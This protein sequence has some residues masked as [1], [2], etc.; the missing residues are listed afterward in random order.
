M[1]LKFWEFVLPLV[2]DMRIRFALAMA[3]NLVI[4]WFFIFYFKKFLPEIPENFIN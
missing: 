1:F 2:K 4:L 3:G